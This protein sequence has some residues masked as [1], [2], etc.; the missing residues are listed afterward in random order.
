MTMLPK[1]TR[2]SWRAWWW[3]SDTGILGKISTESAYA[4]PTKIQHS[5]GKYSI[6]NVYY[7]ERMH[8]I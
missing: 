4:I 7:I 8:S 5:I 6:A 1:I 3:S 2:E